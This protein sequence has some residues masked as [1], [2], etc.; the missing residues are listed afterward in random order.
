MYGTVLRAAPQSSVPVVLASEG[1]PRSSTRPPSGPP[2]PARR[3]PWVGSAGS[4]A[5]SSSRPSPLRTRQSAVL[6]LFMA[7]LLLTG[8]AVTL[9]SEETEGRSLEELA[10]AAQYVASTQSGGLS[11]PDGRLSLT[12]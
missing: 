8:V 9:L 5:R 3:Q 12:L 2:G 7:L 6:G 11:S 1:S 10:P 4:S